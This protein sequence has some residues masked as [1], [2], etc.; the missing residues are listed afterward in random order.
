MQFP[1]NPTLVKKIKIIK[2]RHWYAAGKYWS[3]PDSPGTLEKIL[4]V[5]AKEKLYIDPALRRGVPKTAGLDDLR[6]ELKIRKY[7]SK[8]VKAYIQMKV[9][10]KG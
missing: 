4:G 8:T 5:F 9:F 2:G 7:S 6:N 10:Y 1:Y 3:F